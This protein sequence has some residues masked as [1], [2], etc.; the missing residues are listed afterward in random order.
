M[1]SC[2][3]LT[4]ITNT[5]YLHRYKGE[6]TRRKLCR[7]RARVYHSIKQLQQCERS[8]TLSAWMKYSLDIDSFTKMQCC[9]FYWYA[10]FLACGPFNLDV[11]VC[12]HVTRASNRRSNEW[13]SRHGKCS[14]NP[15]WS[16]HLMGQ[17]CELFVLLSVEP[18]QPLHFSLLLLL[19]QGLFS[20]ISTAT[21]QLHSRLLRVATSTSYISGSTY[22]LLLELSPQLSNHPLP[23][24]RVLPLSSRLSWWNSCTPSQLET[25]Y[26]DQP[27]TQQH[28]LPTYG[29]APSILYLRNSQLLRYE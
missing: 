28:E 19:I 3:A 7:T 16:L 22:Q 24:R 12:D 10:A 21:E 17:Q 6:I 26:Q 1:S 18:S 20:C 29:C 4:N 14:K 27:P 11:V 2:C 13:W 15:F 8:R 5:S 23:G 25:G 9:D